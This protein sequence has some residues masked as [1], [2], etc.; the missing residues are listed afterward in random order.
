MEYLIVSRWDVM[1]R[2]SCRVDFAESDYSSFISFILLQGVSTG[3][4]SSSTL[5]AVDMLALARVN[6]AGAENIRDLRAQVASFEQKLKQVQGFADI[7]TSKC[8]LAA[9]REEYLVEELIKAAKDL[10]CKH[11][12]PSHP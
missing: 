11:K 10:V 4:Y 5:P 1:F 6:E 2:A 12:P 8:K 3:V 9:E 7:A